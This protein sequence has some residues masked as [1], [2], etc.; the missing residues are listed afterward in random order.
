MTG[1]VNTEE[2]MQS[3]REP[4][5]SIISKHL[6]ARGSKKDDYE[7]DLLTVLD[8]YTKRMLEECLA[9]I[10][11]VRPEV[12]LADVARRER[13]AVGHCDYHRKAALY[14][15]ELEKGIGP[16]AA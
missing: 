3:P 2:D 9:V 15:H 8:N 4:Y 14:M 5:Y 1:I 12:T 7:M 10:Q 16:G 6:S 11:Q 13:L